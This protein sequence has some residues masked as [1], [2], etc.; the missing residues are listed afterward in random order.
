MYTIYAQNL[1]SG[2]YVKTCIFDDAS[3]LLEHK[4]ISPSLKMAAGAAG[5]L[6]FEMPQ[7][8]AGYEAIQLLL[9]TVF[10][11][12]DET[13]IWTGRVLSESRDIWGSRKIFC[14]GAL[15][16]LNDTIAAAGTYDS[17]LGGYLR[18]IIFE[19]NAKVQENRRIYLNTISI[20]DPADHENYYSDDRT[21][22]E[23]IR[24]IVDELGGVI[25]LLWDEENGLTLNLLNDY[26][27]TATQV[28]DFGEN[29][30]DFTRTRNAADYCT[31]VYPRGAEWT[32]PITGAKL[33]L[34]I[35]N[36][37]SVPTGYMRIN[38]I[39]LM[40]DTNLIPPLLRGMRI[41]KVVDFADVDDPDVLA[42]CAAE[43]LA[44]YKYGELTLD[45]TALD[46]HIL[47]PEIEALELLD[48]VQVR[49]AWHDLDST[50]AVTEMTIPLDE[51]EKTKYTMGPPSIWYKR[52][53]RTLTQ[54]T[55][56]KEGGLRVI[57]GSDYS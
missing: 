43:W 19:H 32:Q 11:E 10:V 30:L 56:Q 55:A 40:R 2:T 8:N 39:Y 52:P 3:P 13:V 34:T 25:Q 37:T 47:D 12:R 54:K 27:A 16:Y 6:T 20:E 21:T 4:L 14:E 45:V 9:T 38:Q 53:P 49:S 57:N 48:K 41:E 51:P 42:A 22:L 36:A 1:V 33:K 46:L 35:E 23:T 29:L 17:G 31:V 44:T 7:T 24:S 26:P 50:F 5:S 28:L 15:A 18:A